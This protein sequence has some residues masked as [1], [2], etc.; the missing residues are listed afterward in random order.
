MAKRRTI[1]CISLILVSSISA[2]RR[3]VPEFEINLD[4]APEERF[5][6]VLRHFRPSIQAFWHGFWDNVIAKGAFIG[7]T[8]RRGPEPEELQREIEGIAKISGLPLYGIH[9]FQFLYELQTLMVPIEN[10]T[11]PWR[12][13]GC[14]G[15][16]AL[17]K[18]DGMVYHGRNQD[19]APAK[20]IQNLLYTGIF[21]RGGGEVF[22]GQMV[23]LYAFPLTALKK[24]PNGFSTETNTRYTDHVHGNAELLNNLL[25]ERRPLNGWTIRKILE[26]SADYEA[27]VE[28]A[29]SITLTATQYLIIGGVRKGTIL[30]RNP[31][32]LA[33]QLTLG[34]RNYKCRDDYIIVTNF[35]Y[36]FHDVREWFDPTGGYGIGHPRR[37]A[38]QKLL[39][40]SAHLTPDVLWSTIND[41]GVMAK[42]T[43]FQALINVETGSW[44]V[45]L[46][47]CTECGRDEL[48]V[49]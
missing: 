36:V 19:F 39:N 13:P 34:K 2:E 42:D 40:Q 30:A 41:K 49:V 4:A 6:E 44:N 38:A 33:Y 26:E 9:G 20:Y 11:I 24:G 21:T 47:A 14:T 28:A 48:I 45:S 8:K 12:G 5:A 32:N 15:I 17:N 10:F 46:P 29:S 16:L 27:A 31:D 18:E 25:K 7:L 22:R 43:I 35:D 3:S 37:V 1:A 23:A